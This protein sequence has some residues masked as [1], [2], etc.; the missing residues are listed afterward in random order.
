MEDLIQ[1][2][3]IEIIEALNLQDYSPADID[4]DAP[5]FG[6]GL[7]LDSIDSLE[8]MVLLE[9]NYG[10]KIEDPRK[11]REVLESVRS[12]AQFIQSQESEA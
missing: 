2:L 1:K 10:I 4:S 8:L 3:K 12:M 11:G 7:G 5:L 6:S 9:R